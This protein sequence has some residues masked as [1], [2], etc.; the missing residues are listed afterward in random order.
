MDEADIA[1][2]FLLEN[3]ELVLSNASHSIL[4]ADCLIV[5]S[6]YEDL[7]IIKSFL[8]R[9]GQA[10]FDQKENQAFLL[11]EIRDVVLKILDATDSYVINAVKNNNN[12][13][14][15]DVDSLF[16]KSRELAFRAKQIDLFKKELL[17]LHNDASS[18]FLAVEEVGIASDEVLSRTKNSVSIL[19]EEKMVGFDDEV[20]LLL[21]KLTGEEKQLEVIS[22]VG[23]AGI[24][25]TTLAKRLYNDP[26]V[27]YHF[28]VHGWT[29]GLQNLEVKNALHDIL[30]L[31]T[32][33]KKSL[34][35]MTRDE[36]GEKL[37]KRLK[38]KRYLVVIDDIWDFGSWSTM[39]WYFPDDMIGSKILITS[40]IK[41]AVLE[42]SPRNSVHFLRFLNHDESWNL[43][44][45]KVFTNETCP[46]ELMELGSEIV[47]KCEGLPLAIVVLAGLAKK[48]KTQEWWNYINQNTTACLGGEQEKFMG[49]LGLSYQHLPSSLKSCFLYLGSFPW[50]HEIPVKKLIPSWI[51]EGFVE[52]NGEKKVEDVAEDYLKDLVD[53]S[54]VMVSKRR[55][56]GGIKT[57][58]VHDL[59]RDLCVQ[60]A[61]DEK[62]LQ[63]S[64]RIFT[65][66]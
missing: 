49:I 58:H 4:V 39:K 5:I 27:V 1:V 36:I 50:N 38:G 30:S 16:K 35:K 56:N 21:D 41:D 55:S 44:E 12:I 31:I 51:A 9:L 52:S 19:K 45:S 7:K 61:K 46:E 13:T 23:M 40:Q 42:I 3:L 59:L 15:T 47:A 17:S 28:H 18:S 24:G 34:H 11:T 20:T 65:N 14:G 8:K 29:S 63:P 37:Y 57:F 48:N 53:R 62:F 64:W 54:L 6:L 2:E 60:K 33:D 43:F 66:F 26:R 10:P 22:L 25:K 32:D